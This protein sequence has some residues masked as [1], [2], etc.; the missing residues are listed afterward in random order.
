M[1]GNTEGS[2]METAG[3][4]SRSGAKKVTLSGCVLA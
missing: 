2:L 4:A 1:L 3:L